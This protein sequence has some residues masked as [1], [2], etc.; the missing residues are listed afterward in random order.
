MKIPQYCS[1]CKA[2]YE[3]SVVPTS[4][5]DDDGV[6]WLQCPSCK[7]FLPK[8]SSSVDLRSSG[9]EAD[10][11]AAGADLPRETYPGKAER[12]GP[13]ADGTS[14]R[15]GI[16]GADVPSRPEAPKDATSQPDPLEN[17]DISVAMAYRPWE[18]Y[19][20]G[21][22]I[23]HLAWDDYGVVVAKEVLPG[24]RKVV[25][26]KFAEAG[27]VRLIEQEGEGP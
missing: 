17:M 27:T 2:E 19:A 20:E 24:N 12:S 1:V 3:M 9:G 11:T 14:G 10:G 4:D 8:V 18:T 15:P 22:V 13:P 21:D 7:G 16:E 25:Q 26:V 6:V 23:H 5:G